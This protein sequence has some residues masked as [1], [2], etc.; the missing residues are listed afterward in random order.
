MK[1]STIAGAALLLTFLNLMSADLVAQN[2]EGQRLRVGLKESPPF[3][4][5][6]DQGE[7]SG[8]SVDLLRDVAKELNHELDFV[9]ADLKELLSDIEKGRLQVGAAALTITPDRE[10]KFDF[11][12]PYMDSGLGIAVPGEPGSAWAQVAK[13]FLSGRFLSGFGTL[14]GLLLIVGA[15]VWFFERRRNP[16][17]FG[18]NTGGLLE[19]FWFAAVT[20]TTV[21]YGDKSPKT[22]G[23]R[24]VAL[25]WMFTSIVLISGL[26]AAI[27]ASLTVSELESSIQ[28]PEDL[29]GRRVLTVEGS[30]SYEYLR[31]KGIGTETTDSLENALAALARGEAECVVYD[32]PLLRYQI[33]RNHVGTLD[34][35]PSRFERQQYALA[36][37]EASPLREPF[38]RVLLKRIASLEWEERLLRYFGE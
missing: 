6:D 18:E 15:L 30:T 26:T 36:F 25:I 20:M 32:A 13:R 9:E 35:L 14:M 29:R 28:G 38:N 10:E 34:V 8:L 17:E 7:W 12:H 21:G 31:R 3:S 4:M 33:S 11:S 1:L 27:A 37:P 24:F 23:G 19:G 16:E 5:R 22:G 2:P